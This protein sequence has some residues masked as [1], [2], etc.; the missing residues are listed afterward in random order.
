VLRRIGGV[1]LLW[2]R[3]SDAWLN[4]PELNTNERNRIFK[5]LVDEGKI[6][7][8]VV[9]NIKDSLYCLSGDLALIDTVLK[10]T[11]LKGRCEVLAPLDNMLWDRRLI[12]ELFGFEYKWEVYIPKNQRKFGYY[13]LPLLYGDR[14]IGRVEPVCDRKEKTMALE[15]IWYEKDIKQTGKLQKAVEDCMHRLAEFNGC[16]FVGCGRK[17]DAL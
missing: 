13:V 6:T 1:G 2:N 9:E 10:D 17:L 16:S 14:F 7:E 12:R 3:A 5:E 4:I 11:E 15:N 8:V